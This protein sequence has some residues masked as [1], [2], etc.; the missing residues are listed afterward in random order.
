MR[1]QRWTLSALNR[2]ACGQAERAIV[3]M[4]GKQRGVRLAVAALRPSKLTLSVWCCDVAA[5]GVVLLV[6][7]ACSRAEQVT[8]LHE[9]RTKQRA[10][11]RMWYEC[12]ASSFRQEGLAL[13]TSA[14]LYELLVKTRLHWEG[15]LLRP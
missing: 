2:H 12:M 6:D 8:G 13:H 5:T 11:G 1:M 10:S 15:W 3:G 4:E 7:A 9:N 14:P